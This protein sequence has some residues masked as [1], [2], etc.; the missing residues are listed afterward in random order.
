MKAFIDAP[1]FVYLNTLTDGV[2]NL[3]EGFYL[4][5]LSRYKPYTDVLVLDELI[6]ISK[7]KYGIPYDVSI[8]FIETSILPY[9]TII[10]LGEEEYRQAIKF[11]L[12]YNLKPSDTLHLGAMVSNNI[13]LIITE[14]SEFDVVSQIKRLW[15][16]ATPE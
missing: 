11:L 4:D 8:E 6:Y 13:T 2:R 10:S 12:E 7:K 1:L 15:V 16:P 14:D 9:V 3:Y 5:V